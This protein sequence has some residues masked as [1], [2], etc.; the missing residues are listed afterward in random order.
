MIPL[1][2]SIERW[3]LREP[4]SIA[5]G[6]K[7]EAIVVVAHAGE[8]RGECVPYARY[9]ES[10]ELVVHAIESLGAIDDR[11]ALRTVMP[12]GAA[13]NA[14]DLALWDLELK[15]AA[16]LALAPVITAR[17]IVIDT[18]EGTRIKARQHA[19]SPLLKI[20]VGAEHDLER[21]HAIREEAP[22]AKLIVDANEGWTIAQLEKWGPELAR[23][24]VELIEQP[25][26]ASA[27]AVLRG[28]DGIALCADES[29]VGEPS[30]IDALADRYSAVCLKLDKQGGLTSALEAEA[31][32]RACGLSIMIGCM[33]STS[34]AI[35][36]ALQIAQR[37]EWVDLD[38]ALLLGRDREHGLRFE[39]PYLYPP[40]R[41]LWG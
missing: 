23:A 24:G 32:A 21:V 7:T 27:D 25:L 41:L 39:D 5:R 37:A 6:T 3:P 22:N 36:P 19:R 31:R 28:W 4:F 1:R 17:T 34:L 38:G 16:P 10:P 8:G 14:I 29:C 18:L 35:A 9:G 2:A 11:E 13:R 15:R 30:A 20:K 12:A 40:E 26:A 33:V